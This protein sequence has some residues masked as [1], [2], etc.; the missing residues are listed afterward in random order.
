MANKVSVFQFASVAAALANKVRACDCVVAVCFAATKIVRLRNGADGVSRAE[1]RYAYG[2]ER[3]NKRA[4]SLQARRYHPLG[5]PHASVRPAKEPRATL[6]AA[7]PATATS[8]SKCLC[9]YKSDKLI[10]SLCFICRFALIAN[11]LNFANDYLV[12]LL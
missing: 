12:E 10:Y 5:E 8:G 6:T 9:M 4:T 1:W 11:R 2:C 7:A 3:A